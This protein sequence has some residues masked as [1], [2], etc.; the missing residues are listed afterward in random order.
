M[1]ESHTHTHTHTHTHSQPHSLA[2]IASA[3]SGWEGEGEGGVEEVGG[4]SRVRD[5]G[6]VAEVGVQTELTGTQLEREGGGGG[7]G[8]GMSQEEEWVRQRRALRQVF[9]CA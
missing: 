9:G 8:R 6:R 3:L 4:S 1:T 5:V 2:G 7:G